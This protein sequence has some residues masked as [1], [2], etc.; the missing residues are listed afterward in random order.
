M[1]FNLGQFISNNEDFARGYTF[2]VTF[3]DGN[4]GK[5]KQSDKYLVKSSTLPT[6]TI[7]P[8]EASWQ[9]NKYKLAGTQEFTDFTVSFNIN[10]DVDNIRTRFMTWQAAIHDVKT[11][12]HG[13]AGITNG[14][15]SDIEVRHMDHREE[16]KAL[17]T[18]KLI[19]AWPSNVGEVQ[20]T[21][22]STELATFDV[23]F[24]YQYHTIE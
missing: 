6:G 2:Y 1:S 3:T 15:M 19:G 22:D 24:T 7:T 9:G 14:Y 23:S 5:I 12:K 17:A 11:N 8:V 13:T 18:Y 20:L 4:P 10:P 21:Y 16:D